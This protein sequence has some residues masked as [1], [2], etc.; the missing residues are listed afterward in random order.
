[1][2]LTGYKLVFED[3]F[4]GDSLDLNKWQHSGPAIMSAGSNDEA[5]VRVENGNMIIRHEYRDGALGEKWYTGWVSTREK[6]CRGY[7]EARCMCA[8]TNGDCQNTPLSAFWLCVEDCLNPEVSRG[9]IGGA[10]VDIFESNLDLNMP[11]IVT[12]I[13]LAGLTGGKTGPGAY[14]SKF[15][16]GVTIPDCYTNYH[17]YALEWTDK[18][19]RFYVDGLCYGETSFGDGV[20]QVP[21][22][23]IFNLG[24]PEKCEYSKDFSSEYKIDYLRIYQKD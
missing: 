16:G 1:M 10:E 11:G 20:S 14:D 13:H 21:E 4:N 2:D 24:L 5:S 8:E 9:G 17:T 15:I 18:V 3:D 7:F 22:S 19:Y 6:F 12:N 23:V